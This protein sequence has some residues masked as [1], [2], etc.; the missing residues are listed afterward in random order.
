MNFLS[1]VGLTWVFELLPTLLSE[2]NSVTKQNPEL[3]STPRK[4]QESGVEW[5]GRLETDVC[6]CWYL[7][8]NTKA[9]RVLVAKDGSK[10]VVVRE[11]ENKTIEVVVTRTKLGRSERTLGG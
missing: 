6:W 2:T 11:Q 8:Y 5:S 1:V 9:S 3:E 4:V 7:S 10:T